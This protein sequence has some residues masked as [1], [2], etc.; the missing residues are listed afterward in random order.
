MENMRYYQTTHFGEEGVNTMGILME[1]A[2]MEILGEV[3][4][5]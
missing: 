1:N 3:G 5:K 2:E 4:H